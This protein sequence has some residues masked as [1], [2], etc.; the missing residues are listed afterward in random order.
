MGNLKER[1][2]A[3]AVLAALADTPAVLI[4][5]PRQAGKSTLCRMLGGK[6][7]RAFITFD[8]ANALASAR[9]DPQGFV[10]SLPP[11][12]ILDEIQRVP[13]L[14]LALKL[15]IDRARQPGRFL[16]TGSANVLALPRIA[17][18][19]AGR[20]EVV[21]LWPLSQG[22]I[23]G[24]ADRFIARAFGDDFPA[25]ATIA[26]TR[27]ALIERALVGGYPEALTRDAHRRDAWFASYLT[28]ILQRDVRDISNIEGLTELPRILRFLASRAG[29]VLNIADAGRSLALPHTTLARYL[30]LLE[31]TFLIR[32][33]PA[34]AGDTG[35]RLTKAPRMML[36]DTGL[37]A[38]L[39]GITADSLTGDFTRA[40]GLL[41]N[42]A[43]MELVKQAGWSATRPDLYH[44]R[45]Y[46]GQEVDFVL[47]AADGRLVGIEVKARVTV[48]DSDFAGL[49]SFRDAVGRRFRRGIVLH[50]GSATLP[51]GDEMLAAPIGTL[52]Q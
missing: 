37:V 33:I 15:E 27:R 28:T 18:S 3:S 10:A 42:L 47:E 13:E 44:Y 48:S 35:R 20:M 32:K 41:E 29:K 45:S 24:A 26:D 38:H 14:L 9:T 19:L 16:M 21:T 22:E 17:D 52:W 34:W 2:L 1:H 23:E 43:A 6:D 36:V 12:V 25:A 11:R 39:D 51:F 40:G 31:N 8:D 50:G 46:A 5:G 7:G 49:R 4:V 30:S